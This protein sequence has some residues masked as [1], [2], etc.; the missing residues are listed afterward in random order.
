MDIE[1]KNKITAECKELMSRAKYDASKTE[2]F[3]TVVSNILQENIDSPGPQRDIKYR[4]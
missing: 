3:C 2:Q 4:V 1:Q